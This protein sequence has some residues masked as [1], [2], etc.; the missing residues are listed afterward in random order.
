MLIV[1]GLAFFYFCYWHTNS[2]MVFVACVCYECISF[3][4]NEFEKML[5]Y[6]NKCWAS[7]AY[8][9]I[10]KHCISFSFFLFCSAVMFVFIWWLAFYVIWINLMWNRRCILVNRIISLRPEKLWFTLLIVSKIFS[11]FLYLFCDWNQD[12]HVHFM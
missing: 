2:M 8:F 5:A 10:L 4:V 12:N 11:S 1:F 9:M 3:D 7:A 6:Q